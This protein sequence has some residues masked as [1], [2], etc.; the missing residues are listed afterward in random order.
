[1]FVQ[2]IAPSA[3]AVLS[4]ANRPV[5]TWPASLSNYQLQSSDFLTG[6]NWT[7]VTNVPALVNGRNTVI[8]QPTGAQKFYRLQQMQ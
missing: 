1:L 4:I 3:G 6:P 2:E 7:A 8:V 5:I